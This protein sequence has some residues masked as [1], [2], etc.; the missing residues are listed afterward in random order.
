MGK[1]ETGWTKRWWGATIGWSEDW[2]TGVWPVRYD[3]DNTDHTDHTGPFDSLQQANRERIIINPFPIMQSTSNNARSEFPYAAIPHAK[4]R[5]QNAE[6]KMQNV[7][8]NVQ[9]VKLK[10]SNPKP[11]TWVQNTKRC[12]SPAFF[13]EVNRQ[14]SDW[15]SRCLINYAWCRVDIWNMK[16]ETD[17]SGLWTLQASQP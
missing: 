15:Y 10:T 2:V 8:C 5:M 6:C 7:K 9:N 11:K 13:P 17:S 14:E 12:H 3:T 16:T 1:M 4:C